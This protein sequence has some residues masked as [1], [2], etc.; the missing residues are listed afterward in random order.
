MQVYFMFMILLWSPDFLFNFPL[1]RKIQ[2]WVK[3]LKKS[4]GFFPNPKEERKIYLTL[5]SGFLAAGLNFNFSS[6]VG[7]FSIILSASTFSNRE[8]SVH[9]IDEL[10]FN[11]I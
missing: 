7:Q 3:N 2:E 6:F 8:S 1:R 4:D 11:M 5:L 9:G 10:A